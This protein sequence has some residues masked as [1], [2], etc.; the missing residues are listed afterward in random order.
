MGSNWQSTTSGPLPGLS[1]FLRVGLHQDRP[2]FDQRPHNSDDELDLV[3]SM[4]DLIHHFGNAGCR[5]GIETTDQYLALARLGCDLRQGFLMSRPVPAD[6]LTMQRYQ[7]PT[8][9]WQ[10]SP[11]RP[12]TP[13]SPQPVPHHGNLVV[14]TQLL[15]RMPESRIAEHRLGGRSELLNS[16]VGTQRRP[17]PFPQW[18][19]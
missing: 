18:P 3:A 7:L 10:E 16:R 19:P 12:P 9:P 14:G 2:D 8:A 17:P 15:G 4:I 13:P 6:D 5:R 1:S 11:R